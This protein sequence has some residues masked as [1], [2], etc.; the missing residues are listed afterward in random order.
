MG[1]TH[2]NF[3]SL[4][5]LFFIILVLFGSKRLSNIGADLGAAIKSFRAGLE[6]TDEIS[7]S[8]REKSDKNLPKG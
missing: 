3:L 6:S 8:E 1:L 4:L 2:I 7:Q 5:L